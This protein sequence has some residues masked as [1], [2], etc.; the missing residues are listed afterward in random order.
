MRGL[1]V[2]LCMLV[3]CTSDGRTPTTE[4]PRPPETLVQ[5]AFDSSDTPH[6]ATTV[7]LFVWNEEAWVK[8]PMGGIPGPMSPEI[9]FDRMDAMYA[10][11]DDG[12]IYRRAVGATQWEAINAAPAP[13][14]YS[15]PFEAVDGTRYAFGQWNPDGNAPVYFQRPGEAAWIASPATASPF[16][17]MF[18]DE[19]GTVWFAYGGSV[20]RVRELETEL[21][22]VRWSPD[23]TNDEIRISGRAGTQLFAQPHVAVANYGAVFA[24]DLVSHQVSVVSAGDRCEDTGTRPRCSLAEKALLSGLAVSAEGVAYEIRPDPGVLGGGVLFRLDDDAWHPI[25]DTTQAA[26]TVVFDHGGTPYVT[27][28]GSDGGY[29]VRVN[30]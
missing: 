2:S 11:A 26:G 4:L 15:V 12:R 28:A 19:D 13:A 24:W 10:R 6:V 18:A 5:L 3:G 20:R 29:V 8:V 30:L 27:R 1:G 17:R 14:L 21:F 16:S 25:A 7:G 9:A 23:F 22:D